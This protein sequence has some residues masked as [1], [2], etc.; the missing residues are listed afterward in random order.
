METP[1]FSDAVKKRFVGRQDALDEF[2]QRFAYIH[3]QN[4]VYYWGGGGT[5]KTWILQK[6]YIDNLDD[7]TRTVTRII[8]FFDTRNQSIRGLQASIQERL[9]VPNLPEVFVPYT[10]IIAQLEA[11]RSNQQAQQGGQLASLESRANKVF[12]ECCQEAVRDRK[13]IL[14]LDTFER[15]QQRDVGQWLLK[16]FLTQVTGLIVAMAG[17]PAPPTSPLPAKVPDNFISYELAGLALADVQEY[18]QKTWPQLSIPENII[19][20]IYEVAEGNPLLLDLIFDLASAEYIQNLDEVAKIRG[21]ERLKRDLIQKHFSEAS[22]LNRVIW[23]MAY[24]KRR[25]DMPTLK[26]I[27]DSGELLEL[28]SGGFDEIITRLRSFKF[29]KEYPEQENHLLHDEMQVIITEYLLEQ[30]DSRW[31]TRGKLFELV[32]MNYYSQQIAN[33]EDKGDD[34]LAKQLKAEQFGYMLER[35]L[36]GKNLDEGLR[37]YRTYR[38]Q[39]EGS[40]DYDFEELLWGEVRDQLPLET[41]YD[42]FYERG[43][44]LS[45]HSLFS[46][47]EEHFSQMLT[48][49]PERE[50]DILKS[51]GFSQHRQGN[52]ENA[53]NTFSSGI[54]K[55]AK[56]DFEELADFENLLGQAK[57]FYG[58]WDEALDHYTRSLSAY[59]RITDRSGMGR[60]YS[61]R[62]HIYALQ[63]S[64]VDAKQEA[65]RAI[66][67]L[68]ALEP[69]SNDIEQRH[70]FALLNLGTAYRHA[71]EYDEAEKWY[72]SCLEKSKQINHL[73]GR[74][75]ALENLGINAYLLGRKAQRE[76][77]DFLRD[78]QLQL[79]AL[80]YLMDALSIAGGVEWQSALADGL[81]RLARVYE[82]LHRLVSLTRDMK[83]TPL[84]LQIAIQDLENNGRVY[85]P[86]TEIEYEHDLL[87]R[88]DFSQLNWLEKS[89]R[90]FELSYLIADESEDFH[91]ALDSLMEFARLLLDL[92]LFTIVPIVINRM[93]RIK[94][95]DYQE[96][97]F[98]AIA[99]ITQADLDFEQE[100]YQSA[101]DGYV[102]SYADLAKQTGYASYLLTDRLISLDVRI[103][104]LPIV[105]RINWCDRLED[106]WLKQSVSTVRP[107]M[108]RLLEDIRFD[109]LMESG[110][111]T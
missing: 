69:K 44:W 5:G 53:I 3:M 74:C 94:G 101:L 36:R 87:M 63:G 51:L 49:Y 10:T 97:L 22:D 54:E 34:T 62:S 12:I 43:Q 14:L 6:I 104:R 57:R 38:D 84:E 4:G 55:V 21:N 8:D 29:V 41:G 47:A 59:Q 105:E 86:A 35:S 64:Y 102:I 100:K 107:D 40:H 11:A 52:I 33:A 20:S 60:V 26:F 67:L 24:L 83:K 110:R 15:V 48:R 30:V 61:N 80:H 70:M 31:N 45:K 28:V 71:G 25:F 37:P 108:L 82:E 92:Q 95:Y 91:R 98:S 9:L 46:K 85:Q 17:R 90:L 18:I 111:Q 99:G 79:Q 72:L 13:V 58:R 89:A 68:S 50:V 27:V 23:A 81:S 1:P 66:N 42:I 103:R 75:Q 88:G 73:Q 16:E 93:E 19:H 65:Q 7:P 56:D 32:V 106:A 77:K 2:Y 109:A 39:V 78:A 76:K 96:M